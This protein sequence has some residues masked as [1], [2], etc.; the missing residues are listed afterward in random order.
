[1]QTIRVNYAEGTFYP[2][3]EE[4]VEELLRRIVEQESSLIQTDLAKHKLIGGIV[5]HAGYVYCA[6]EAV[7]F[8]EIVRLSKQHF[9]VILII[10]PNHSGVGEPVSIDANSYWQTAQGKVP[11]DIELGK[12]TDLPF[13]T[14]SQRSE[15]SGEVMLPYIQYF[16]GNNI[17][18]LPISFAAQ[19]A[20]NAHA[21]GTILY[22]SCKQLGR[23]PL[24]IASS[25]FNHFDTPEHGKILDDYA[26]EALLAKDAYAFEE[27]IRHRHISICGY[28]CI[29]A[30]LSFA[31]AVSKDYHI[32]ILKRGN[33]G[34]VHP[35]NEVVD[36]VSA[37]VYK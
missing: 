9:D 3:T 34:E 28:G 13:D 24:V 10:N 18:I 8:F 17:P 25:D 12:I 27:R 7:H 29:L 5:P 20:Y 19:S 15:H 30:L 35:S 31:S 37:L 32:A 1:M 26:L 36:Y 21:L 23:S 11:I 16:L 2:D 22:D 4:E 6:K 33:S 14:V